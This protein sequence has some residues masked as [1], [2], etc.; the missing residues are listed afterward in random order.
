MVIFYR[1]DILAAPNP[2]A[3]SK[4]G[5]TWEDFHS[6]RADGRVR[7]IARAPSPRRAAPIDPGARQ[8]E[9]NAGFR[10]KPAVKWNG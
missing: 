7:Q 3:T 1:N 9:R 4:H 5:P 2:N 6:G 8:G 10:S